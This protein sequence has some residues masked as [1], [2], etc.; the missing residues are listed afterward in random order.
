M[1]T[2]TQKKNRRK[3]AR[4]RAQL[5]IFRAGL[6]FSGG[7]MGLT[8]L[9]LLIS[10]CVSK[11]VS[12]LPGPDGVQVI[13]VTVNHGYSP[14]NFVAQSGKPLKIEFYRDEEP[15]AESC[16]RELDIPSENVHIPLPARESQIVEIKPQP[17]GSEVAFQCGMHMMKGKIS[18]K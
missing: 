9:A 13:K 18:F 3:K 17:A 15:G 7:L 16:A 6:V 2:S 11:P 8:T 12:A 1:L 4:Q 10:G 5:R 14:N